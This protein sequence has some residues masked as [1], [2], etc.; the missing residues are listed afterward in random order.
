MRKASFILL[1]FFIVLSAKSQKVGLVLSGGGAKG[2]AHI[3]VI[4]AL[5][6]NGI[7]IDYIAGTSMGAIIGGLYAIGY[8]TEEMEALIKSEAFNNWAFGIMP[9]EYK[10]YFKEEDA[11]PSWLE[12]DFSNDSVFRP[13]LPTNLVPTHQMDFAFMELFSPAIAKAGYDFDSLFVPYR[14][15][16]SDVH[17]NS[18]V[19]FRKGEL[20]S[21]IR[22]SMTYPF[23]FKP[24][25][26]NGKLLFDG[27]MHNNF[28]I[29]VMEED[30]KPDIIIGSKVVSNSQKPTE[31]DLILQIENMLL[32]K[33]NYNIPEEKGVL[34]EPKIQNVGLMDFSKVDYLTI[35]GYLAANDKIEEIKSRI[36]RRV[37]PQTIR[38]QRIAYRDS[39]PEMYFQNIDIKGLNSRQR[40]YIT[41][42]LRHNKKI[43]SSNELKN[44]YFKLIA[45]DKIESIYPI[46]RYNPDTRFFDLFLDIKKR[47]KFKAKIGGNISSSPINQMFAG[48]EFR[49]LNQ[50]A[51]SI[52]GN[53]FFGKFYSSAQVMGR[54]DVPTRI[55]FFIDASFT[56]NRWDYFR[57]NADWFFIDVKPAFLIQNETNFQSNIGLPLGNKA[58]F[59]SGFALADALDKYYQTDYSTADFADKTYFDY[60]TLH[61]SIEKKTLNYAQYGN[62]GTFASFRIRFVDGMETYY[63]G[64]TATTISEVRENHSWFSANFLLN[65]Y[66]RSGK[67]YSLGLYFQALHSTQDFLSNYNSTMLAAPVFSPSPHSSTQFLTN[68]RAHSFVAAG[69]K[70]V[71]SITEKFDFRIEEY[72]FQPYRKIAE[73][74]S[75]EAVYEKPFIHRYFMGSTAFIYHTP[76]GPAAISLNYYDKEGKKFYLLFNFGYILFNKRGIY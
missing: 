35:T 70:N 45:D 38:D 43:I 33:T 7:P 3:G 30:F 22:A 29:D 66:L 71:F 58:R 61:T 15:L 60:Y 32:G 26:V 65:K 14:C 17:T 4:R 24:V 40:V 27:G 20:P 68:Y 25:T 69:L 54:M 9:E 23:Y 16:A 56:F 55:P 52:K 12:L 28:P 62:K 50:Q 49:H 63:P 53:A 5:E 47:K 13:I 10:F 19:V 34:I 42:S 48:F 2:L 41:R 18:P 39:L 11:T 51:Y 57:S 73:S 44:Q 6:E 59:I 37:D 46:S 8:S 31:D 64:T 74:S 21:A 36:S 67:V 72:I 76:A 1:V 75:H